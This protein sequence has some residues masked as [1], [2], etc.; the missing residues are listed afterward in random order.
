MLRKRFQSASKSIKEKN[1]GQNFS[2]DRNVFQH[3]NQSANSGYF[4]FSFLHSK[5]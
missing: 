4:E 3:E 1:F 2:P 5:H